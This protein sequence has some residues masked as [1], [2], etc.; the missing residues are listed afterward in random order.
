MHLA[1]S[2]SFLEFILLSFV[3]NLLTLNWRSPKAISSKLIVQILLT[4]YNLYLL[5]YWNQLVAGAFFSCLVWTQTPTTY[6]TSILYNNRDIWEK[7]VTKWLLGIMAE[8]ISLERTG[9][10]SLK[11][12]D[13]VEVGSGYAVVVGSNVTESFFFGDSSP[14]SCPKPNSFIVCNEFYH[15]NLIQ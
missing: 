14:W 12:I 6:S 9:R 8:L 15:F 5:F 11:L 7:L 10:W 3:K 13:Q 2:S 1:T 4:F